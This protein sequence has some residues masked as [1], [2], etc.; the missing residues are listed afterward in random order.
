[1]PTLEEWQQALSIPRIV[2]IDSS[3][4]IANEVNALPGKQ[5]FIDQGGIPKQAI[6]LPLFSPPRAVQV[7]PLEILA[8]VGRITSPRTDNLA[9][10]CSTW[11]SIRYIWA[12]EPTPSG[13]SLHL[14]Q[15]AKRIDSHQK[16]LLSDEIGLGMAYYIVNSYLDGT[17]PIDV[18]IILDENII[19][20]I[21]QVYRTK[22]DY[23]FDSP[24]GYI[25]V[26]CKGSQS[27][28][29]YVK[30][31]LRRGLEQVPSL[32]FQGDA[33]PLT[34]VIGTD[35]SSN[36]VR[37]FIVDP[38]PNDSIK[39]DYRKK[40]IVDRESFDTKYQNLQASSLYQFIGQYNKARELVH[41][42]REFLPLAE[43]EPIL[44]RVNEIEEDYI[45]QAQTLR[46]TGNVGNVN[47][48]QGIPTTVYQQIENQNYEGLSRLG[49]ISF[50]KGINVSHAYKRES[51]FVVETPGVYW[52][53][54][55]DDTLRA[56]VIDRDG[57]ITKFE[58]N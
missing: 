29:D 27:G 49:F 46:Y 18:E 38:P 43:M 40:R 23:I 21:E 19:Q 28:Y 33:P 47:I 41:Y 8:A 10:V 1:M 36:G 11:A 56:V 24:D 7:T 45:G 3:Q 5:T 12:F 9:D 6:E 2:E 37:V 58:I 20:N 35:L 4:A 51:N 14:S 32:E 52:V 50:E 54:R 48:F 30:K 16:N 34:L 26:E 13:T 57:A 39:K 15:L 17:N 55:T 31:Q 42:Q 22:P 25:V 53:T 44:Y